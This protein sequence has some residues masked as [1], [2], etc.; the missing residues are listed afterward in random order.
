MNSQ[1]QLIGLI[2]HP[3]SHSKSPE[4]HNGMF[5]K[6]DL[7]YVYLAFD[8]P[9]S[10][11]KEAIEGMKAL[12]IKGFNV[13]IPHK[14]EV[15][16]YLDQVSEEA[17][18]I[19]AVNTIV[20]DEGRLIG[21]NTDGIGYLRSLIEETGVQLKGKRVLILGAG[22]AARA[23]GYTIANSPIGQLTIINRDQ[24][25]AHILRKSLEQYTKTDVLS[26]EQMEKGVK[27]ADIIVNTTS[28]GM[29]P[30]IDQS[31]IKKEWIQPNHLVSDIIY[32]PLETKLIQEARSQ[33]AQV[34]SGLGMFIYQ[35]VI[36]FEKWTG[37]TPD[38]SYMRLKVIES[39]KEKG[40]N[41]C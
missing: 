31:L 33:G 11:L 30:N 17:K 28:I 41:T 25:K 35:G 15:M 24:N 5:A 39:I 22:G 34:H 29:A 3:V 7:N 2:G 4:M 10:H 40:R 8:V 38:P 32:N 19:G 23:I 27:E 9:P 37:I 16:K 26:I 13:T 14:V 12:K 6:L 21:Y 18:Q 20:N 1:T 36:A